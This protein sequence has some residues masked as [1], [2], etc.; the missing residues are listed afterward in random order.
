MTCGCMNDDEYGKNMVIID[1]DGLAQFLL[2]G[3]SDQNPP[4]G[5]ARRFFQKKTH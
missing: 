3:L 1:H 5:V 2:E 4:L